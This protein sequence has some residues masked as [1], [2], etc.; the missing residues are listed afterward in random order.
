MAALFAE[1]SK[2]EF[3]GDA[4]P[5]DGRLAQHEVRGGLDA[6]R[7]HGGLLRERLLP[8]YPASP[9]E[10]PA[11]GPS[12]G[13][14]GA[15]R[16]GPDVPRGAVD[17]TPVTLLDVPAVLLRDH[18]CEPAPGSDGESSAELAL[19]QRPGRTVPSQYHDGW[20]LTGC[21]MLRW[22]HLAEPDGDRIGEAMWTANRS[23]F[24]RRIL[25]RLRPVGASPSPKSS[26]PSSGPD[27][28]GD[29]GTSPG[30]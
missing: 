30:G 3:D 22:D 21:F 19:G 2:N 18:G 4:G 15:D 14:E 16:T 5:L 7:P 10:R 11:R 20:S 29:T 1:L 6:E 24:V 28:G 13:L 9:G 27:T 23:F 25:G 8:L 17:S 26:T 12:A